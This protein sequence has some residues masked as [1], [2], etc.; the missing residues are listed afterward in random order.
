MCE[1][2][3]EFSQFAACAG[4]QPS[5][6]SWPTMNVSGDC[7]PLQGLALHEI[8]LADWSFPIGE[9]FDL[10][11]LAARVRSAW[12]IMPLNIYGGVANPPNAM[13]IFQAFKRGQPIL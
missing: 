1:M 3:M 11:A 12:T 9:M 10:E 13:A 7:D 4:D 8:M 6:E 2:V 5:W